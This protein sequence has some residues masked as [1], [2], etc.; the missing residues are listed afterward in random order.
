[1]SYDVVQDNELGH[2]IPLVNI[3]AL[4]NIS[5]QRKM[6]LRVTSMRTEIASII[7]CGRRTR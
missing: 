4:I 1:M 3:D 7:T 2:A 5:A 6:H